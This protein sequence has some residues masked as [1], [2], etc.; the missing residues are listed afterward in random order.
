MRLSVILFD[1]AVLIVVAVALGVVL[2]LGREVPAPTW[3]GTLVEERL[4]A[5]LGTGKAEIGTVTLQ[6]GR[7]GRPRV[8]FDD[9]RLVGANGAELLVVPRLGAALDKSALFAGRIQPRVLTIEGASLHLRRDPDGRFD[10]DFG[11]GGAAAQLGSLSEALDTLDQAF[12]LPSLS[13]ITR[14]E[15]TD[16]TV[17]FEDVR[18]ARAWFSEDGAL[19]LDQSEDQ[20]ELRLTMSLIEAADL[21]QDQAAQLALTLTSQK[22][23][24]EA[25]FAAK[26]DHVAA[27]DIASQ[28]PALSWLGPLDARVSG[29]LMADLSADLG[30]TELQGTLQIGAG[31]LRPEEQARGFPIDGA[32]AYF[33][34]DPERQRL[35]F[36][37]FALSAPDIALE[38]HGHALLEGLDTGWPEALVG[39]LQID[40][41]RFNPDDWFSEPAEFDSGALDVKFTADPFTARIGQLVLMTAPDEGDSDQVSPPKSSRLSARGTIRADPEG[42]HAA[43][44]LNVPQIANDR[45]LALWPVALEPKTRRW[46]T[47]NLK[48]GLLYNARAALWLEPEV[49]PEVSMSFEFRDAVVAPLPKLPAITGAAGY[50]SMTDNRFTLTLETG[51][52][53]PP[54]GGTLDLAGSV[55]VVP[56]VRAK[57]TPAE[58]LWQSRG[59]VI[60]ALSLLD[61]DPFTFLS[62]AGQPVDVASGVALITGSV[63]FPMVKDV[64]FDMVDLDLRAEAANVRSDKLIAGRTLAA[65]ALAVRANNDELVITGDGTLDGV[66]LQASWVLPLGKGNPPS[67][68]EGTVELSQNAVDTFNIGLAKGT[69]SGVGLAQ[70]TIDLVKGEAPRFTLLSDLNRVGLR[71]SELAWSKSKSATGKLA[72]SGRLGKVPAIDSLNL[73]APGLSAVGQVE[74]NEGGG[75]RAA[76][77]S[78]VRAGQWIDAPVTLTGRGRGV[79]P[80]VSVIGGWIDVRRT[81]VGQ[82]GSGQ[83]TGAPMSLA[84]DRLIISEGLSLTGFRGNLSQKGG[85]SG[86]FVGRVNGRAPIAGTLAPGRGG[87]TAVRIQSD[88]AGRVFSAAGLFKRAN[89]GAMTLTL[90]PRAEKGQYDG[91]LRIKTM[92]VQSAQGLTALLNAISVVGLLEQMSGSG[93]LLSTVEAEFRLTPNALEVRRAS[94]V[95]PSLGISM[96]GIYSMTQDKMDMRGVFSPIYVVNGIGQ[97]FSRRGEGLFGFNYRMTGSADNP[98]VA[99]NPLSVLTPGIFR[100]IFRAPPPKLPGAGN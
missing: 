21:P 67:S 73:S 16:L 81:S 64:T 88:D 22:D 71:I 9:V 97:I 51:K 54:Q 96:S 23:S 63:G 4:N 45:L 65:P 50:A 85:L 38:A 32:Q 55:L 40:S 75:L 99:V 20:V 41:A 34:F 89:G 91:S 93:L 27:A 10:L 25:R 11:T 66:P 61:M 1:I 18:A 24:P 83:G 52:V 2:L 100:E 79:T 78:R 29:A 28:S 62:D 36:D 8:F 74:L 90:L 46:L 58:L 53:T 86:Q 77:F 6:V 49:K 17:G 69:I 12:A 95:G 43:L 30:L 14:I 76:K 92:R 19:T 44:E 7:T 42:W 98:R 37:Q 26:I 94:G 33:S 56:D 84:L 47:R 72:V 60:A 15:A 68:V 13:P 80:A 3:I 35:T 82:G 87:R 31:E 59:P 70:F 57:P 5:G 48:T 39:Q